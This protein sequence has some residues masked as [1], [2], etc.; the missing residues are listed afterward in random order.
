MVHYQCY[1][2][3]R[4]TVHRLRPKQNYYVDVFVRNQMTGG[5]SRYWT[6][7]FSLVEPQSKDIGREKNLEQLTEQQLHDSLFTGVFLDAKNKYRKRLLYKV[8]S[9]LESKKLYIYLQP[10]D[11]QGPVQLAIRQTFVYSDRSKRHNNVDDEPNIAEQLIFGGSH[12]EQWNEQGVLLLEEVTDTKTFEI[13]LPISDVNGSIILEFE[14]NNLGQRR[15]RNMVLLASNELGKFPFPRLPHDR[16]IRV[17]TKMNKIRYF[18]GYLHLF[19]S[20]R[21]LNQCEVVGI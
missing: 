15:A 2:Q 5:A 19:Y 4:A 20:N 3:T 18:T 10:C 14:L 13:V 8:P 17:C 12:D 7:N 9:T 16:T 21:N 1:N 11:G 6:A